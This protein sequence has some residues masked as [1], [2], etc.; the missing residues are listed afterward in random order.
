MRYVVCLFARFLYILDRGRF[1]KKAY[2]FLCICGC[3]FAYELSRFSWKLGYTFTRILYNRFGLIFSE[4]SSDLLV[5][6]NFMYDY[7]RSSDISICIFRTF[8]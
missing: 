8:V 3:K 5:C 4:F 2:A 7:R 6:S 1:H